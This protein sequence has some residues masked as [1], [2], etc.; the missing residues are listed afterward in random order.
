MK[1][2]SLSNRTGSGTDPPR[3]ATG[4]DDL[5]TASRSPLRALGPQLRPIGVH[6]SLWSSR[7]PRMHDDQLDVTSDLVHRLIAEQFPRWAALPVEEVTSTGTVNAIFRIGTSLVARLPLTPH[8]HD[9]DFE[10]WWLDFLRPRLPV[11]IPEVVEVGT[12]SDDYPFPWAVF[13]WIEGEPWRVELLDDPSRE[14]DHL[15]RIV[16]ALRDVEPPSTPFPPAPVGHL[17]HYDD[18]FRQA[19]EQNRAYIDAE[20]ALGVWERALQAPPAHRED[21]VL[22]HRDL[23]AG[24]V[25]V[26][27]GHLAA[28]IDWAAVSRGDPARELI[29]AWTLFDDPARSVFLDAVECVCVTRTRAIGWVLAA[30]INNVAYYA[31]SNPHFSQD[32]RMSIH[33]AIADGGR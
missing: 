23:L 19:L 26:D 30:R 14:A 1:L 22:M 3:R 28:V 21:R 2:P 32:A 17:A 15:A 18:N 7:V 11:T 29:A 5:T 4:H 24:N 8:W 10:R 12:P 25:I 6:L 33:R 31:N 20:A 27:Q 13:T 16:H 9:L